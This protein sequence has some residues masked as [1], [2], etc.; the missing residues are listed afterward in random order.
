MYELTETDKKNLFQANGELRQSKAAY[1]YVRKHPN[2]KLHSYLH[3]TYM[4]NDIVATITCGGG[5]ELI[6]ISDMPEIFQQ[7]D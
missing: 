3:R 7:N 6:Y 2:M 4:L 5:Y 1:D